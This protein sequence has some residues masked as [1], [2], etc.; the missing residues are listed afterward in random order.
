MKNKLLMVILAVLVLAGIGACKK[1]K[2]AAEA[3]N[4]ENATEAAKA[5][6]K[7]AK[8][9]WE[10]TY[11]MAMGHGLALGK[12][13]K[14]VYYDTYTKGLNHEVKYF[15]D[16]GIW[17]IGRSDKEVEEICK[18]MGLD[19]TKLTMK[20]KLELHIIDQLNLDGENLTY[21][22]KLQKTNEQ[23]FKNTFAQFMK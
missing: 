23:D 19:L 6:E 11:W 2:Q 10:G 1:G 22:Y 4:S 14:G 5:G 16:G 7:K 15:L 20:E 18:M 13:G 3:Q 12:D 8:N 21:T 17:Y 9:P